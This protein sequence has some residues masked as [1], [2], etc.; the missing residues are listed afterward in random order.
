[1]PVVA[2]GVRKHRRGLGLAQIGATLFFG[3]GIADDNARLVGHF[4]TTELIPRLKRLLFPD[5]QGGLAFKTRVSRISHTR[6]TRRTRLDLVPQIRQ[7]RTS[8]VAVLF[9]GTP[10]Q[11]GNF[12]L[13]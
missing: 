7:Y 9:G 11:V 12:M 8:K 10:G 4:A 5:C 6:W 2:V 3:H 13:P 1:G